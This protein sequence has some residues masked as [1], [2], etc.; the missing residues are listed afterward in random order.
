MSIETNVKEYLLE[1][2]D[3]L[4]QVVRELNSWNSCLDYLYVYDF[5]AEFFEMMY[6]DN[7]ADAVKA[8]HF[9]GNN[10]WS[11]E[12]I[13]FDGYGNLETLS[14]YAYEQE[15]KDNINEIVAKLIEYQSHVDLSSELQDLLYS[16]EDGE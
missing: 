6:P 11:D 16:T 14:K 4:K 13:R 5:D 15:F 7:T 12:Y 1:N 3:E 10:R 8:W 2:M 9:G